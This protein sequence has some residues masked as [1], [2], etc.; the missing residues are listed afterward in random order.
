MKPNIKIRKARPEDNDEITAFAFG[1]MR[2]LGVEPD[3]ENIDYDF[4]A[5]SR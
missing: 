4:D 3:P 1:I 2:S 5:L